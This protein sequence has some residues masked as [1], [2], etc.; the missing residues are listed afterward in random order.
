MAECTACGACVNICTYDA[1]YMNKTK[2]GFLYPVKNMSLCTEC[3]LCDEVC[4]LDKEDRKSIFNVC[5]VY[6][7]K[8]LDDDVRKGS[9]SGGVFH[10][11]A[12]YIVGLGGMVFGAAYNGDWSVSHRKAESCEEIKVLRR[13][14]YQQSDIGITYRE[15]K[16]QL[17]KDKYVLFV[18]TP[19]QNAGLKRYLQKNYDKLFLCDFICRGV[20][21]PKLF[22]LYIDEL[23]N[24]YNSKI[25][26]ICMKSKQIGWHDL[27]TVIR[28]ENGEEY[29]CS[30]HTDSYLQMYIRYN[31]GVR[32]SCYQC[33]FKGGDSEADITI[34]DFWGIEHLDIDDNLGTSAVICRNEKAVDLIRKIKHKFMSIQ[35]ELSDVIKGN[36]CLIES[37]GKGIILNEQLFD[38]IEEYGYSETYSKISNRGEE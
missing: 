20:T 37:L 13:S 15:V 34:G 36:P 24:R 4:H 1:I 10:E 27:T 26:D 16:E 3:G 18:G 30:G 2:E 38:M 6:A 5:E 28:F 35:V 29:V 32:E 33:Q 8:N 14:K 12:R 9:T 31:V 23:E 22:K 21:S 11:L 7:M 25:Q 17:I 19:C